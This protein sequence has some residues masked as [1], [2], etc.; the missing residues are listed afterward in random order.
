[1]DQNDFFDEVRHR[2]GLENDARTARVI[3]AV[4]SVLAEALEPSDA[5]D[6]SR[7]LPVDLAGRMAR[8]PADASSL[9]SAG[10]LYDRVAERIGADRGVALEESQVVLQVLAEHVDPE[11]LVRVRKRL[12]QDL[13]VL[14]SPR[15]AFI[16]PP[17]NPPSIR[18]V[19]T[20][21]D[22]LATGRVGSKHPLSEA[23]PDRAHQNSI[24]KN[25]DPHGDTKLSSARG[26]RQQQLHDSVADAARDPG[27]SHRLSQS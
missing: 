26:L 23:E 27:P 2:S 12:P 24:A 25:P 19:P 21:R 4:V 7:G 1:M 6:L 3:S 10:E 9:S 5:H 8:E 18:E 20:P 22:T 13:A 17:R 15:P 11:V 14:L 16:A